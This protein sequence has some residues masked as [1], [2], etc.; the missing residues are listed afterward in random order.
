MTDSS[1]A[2]AWNLA[3][4]RDASH[5]TPERLSL[6]EKLGYGC[7]DLSS[8]LTW[9]MTM[10]Y[11]MYYYTDIYLIPAAAVAW[12]LLIPRIFDGFC[13]PLFGY[14]ID[15]TSGRHVRTMIGVLAV[16][17]GVL[18]FLCFLPLPLPPAGKVVWAWVSYLAFGAIYSAIN[19]PYG[20]LG[21]MMTTAPQERVTL[22]AFRMAGCQLGQLAVAAL[23]LPAIALLGGGADVAH[24]QRGVAAFSLILALVGTG[25][26]FLTWRSAKIRKP[27]PVTNHRLGELIR[28][29][30][31]NRLWH[32]CNSLMFLNFLVFCSEAALIIHYTRFILHRPVATAGVLLTIATLGAVVGAIVAPMLTKRLG[33]RRTYGLMLLCE[34]AG[35]SVMLAAGAHFA[36]FLTAFTLQYVCVGVLSPLCYAMLAEA[37]DDGEA[38]TGVAATGLAY[39]VN[40]LITKVAVGVTGFI[41]ATLL[42]WGHYAPDLKAGGPVLIFWL[43]AG[44]LGVPASAIG[45]ALFVLCFWPRDVRRGEDLVPAAS[46]GRA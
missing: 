40:S 29:L 21:N 9:G 8:N 22:N 31:R 43:K 39:S 2:I 13:D 44:F 25:L 23:T 33:I 36:L 34:L 10:S 46:M 32:L 3:T 14:I 1:D 24:Q 45:L 6:W 15:R 19:T 42:V 12:L 5:P 11:L 17:F 4:A 26:W 38:R 18:A 41:V 16:P 7:G 20:A 27:L 37:I 30:A 28:S 35:L